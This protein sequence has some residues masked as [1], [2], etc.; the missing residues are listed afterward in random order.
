[1]NTNTAHLFEELLYPTKKTT[2]TLCPD[3]DTV[4]CFTSVHE[5]EDIIA[6]MSDHEVQ[7]LSMNYDID[8]LVPRFCD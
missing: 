1:M 6:S 7:A 4:Y 5:F 2:L 3:F 8:D